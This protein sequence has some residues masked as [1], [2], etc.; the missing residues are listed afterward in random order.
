[1]SA[2]LHTAGFRIVAVDPGL[3]GCG[4]AEFVGG[5]LQRAA[6]VKNPVESGRGYE[7]HR[8]MGDAVREWAWERGCAL[9]LIEH[10]RVYPGSAQQKGD[11][12]DLLDL[13]G[14]GGAI[15]ARMGVSG[16]NPAI[17][18]V[19]PSDWKGQVPKD[20]MTE[21]IRRCMTEEERVRIA[22]CPASLMHN[23]L[24]GCG[25]GLYKLGRL[26]KKGIY[27]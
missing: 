8:R 24:D 12:N 7:A 6:Y 4:V 13:T 15:A 23:V 21:R 20:M 19:F 11:L 1:L 9:L 5:E 27:P 16:S 18:T 14:V 2:I 3:R 17:E 10:P 22:K 26:N 25:I